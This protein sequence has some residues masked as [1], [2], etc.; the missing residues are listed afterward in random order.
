M[1]VLIK[2]TKLINHFE[3]FTEN[4]ILSSVVPIR[5]PYISGGFDLTSVC[6]P[7]KQRKFNEV[8]SKHLNLKKLNVNRSIT[9]TLIFFGKMWESL[10]KDSNI[11]FNKT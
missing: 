11:F 3:N 2:V 4:D 8:S 6:G 5:Q 1:A 9:K 7:I 10:S